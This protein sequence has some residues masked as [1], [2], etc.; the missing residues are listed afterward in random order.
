MLFFTEL[1]FKNC[2]KDLHKRPQ[3]DKAILRKKNGAGRKRLPEYRLYH[4]ATGAK[5]LST[6]V[7]KEININRTGHKVQR[8]TQA[9]MVI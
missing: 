2:R 6:D 4:K 9:P 3:I 1:D 7:K 5:Q 8:Y